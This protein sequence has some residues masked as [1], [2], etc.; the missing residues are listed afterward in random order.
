MDTLPFRGG[1]WP[2]QPENCQGSQGQTIAPV[3]FGESLTLLPYSGPLMTA[4]RVSEAFFPTTSGLPPE[5][6]IAIVA[7]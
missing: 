6:D 1:T 2:P 7:E 3:L 5:A 4:G